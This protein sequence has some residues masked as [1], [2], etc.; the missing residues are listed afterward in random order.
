[1]GIYDGEEIED[2]A[3]YTVEVYKANL[4]FIKRA[5]LCYGKVLKTVLT[6]G[7]TVSSLNIVRSLPSYIIV[8][9]KNC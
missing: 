9:A 7:I 1:M 3:L 4:F 8:I 2:L 5:C 6:D